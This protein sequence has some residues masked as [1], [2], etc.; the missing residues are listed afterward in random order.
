VRMPYGSCQLYLFAYV[1]LCELS[2]RTSPY[3]MVV[4]PN[5]RK[6]RPCRARLRVVKPTS[7]SHQRRTRDTARTHCWRLSGPFSRTIP[8]GNSLLHPS[9][10]PSDGVEG[11]DLR[12]RI[13]PQRLIVEFA[14]GSTPDSVRFPR[15]H[16][17]ASRPAPHGSAGSVRTDS[18]RRGPLGSR[19]NSGASKTK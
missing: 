5:S 8:P 19:H 10:D 6:P 15:A 1:L 3:F 9:A 18:G 2:W 14:F 7:F 17:R 16:A 13:I 12:Q 11:Q 4:L